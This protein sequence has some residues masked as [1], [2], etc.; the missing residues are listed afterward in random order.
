MTRAYTDN[1]AA[2]PYPS[3][4]RGNLLPPEQ[5]FEKTARTKIARKKKSAS[6]ERGV[7]SR[8]K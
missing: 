4:V 7:S 8:A 1:T 2:A 6:S 5:G 3:L